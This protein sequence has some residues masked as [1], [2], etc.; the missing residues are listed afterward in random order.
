MAIEGSFSAFLDNDYVSPIDLDPMQP[1]SMS[2]QIF[3]TSQCFNAAS[4]T[5]ALSTNEGE[6]SSSN[7]GHVHRYTPSIMVASL[8]FGISL[9]ISHHIY[10]SQPSK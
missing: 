3:M 6:C 5:K 4:N 10:Y 7:Q 8:F 9:G 2:G 1:S